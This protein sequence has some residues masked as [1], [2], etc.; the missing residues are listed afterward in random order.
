MVDTREIK[1]KLSMKKVVLMTLT[2]LFIG[3]LVFFGSCVPL[4]GFSE[5]FGDKYVIFYFFSFILSVVLTGL[6]CYFIIKRILKK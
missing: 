3:P 1:E 5:S 2:G 6:V 4:L